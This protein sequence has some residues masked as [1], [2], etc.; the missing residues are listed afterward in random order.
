MFSVQVFELHRILEVQKQ[1]AISPNLLVDDEEVEEEQ[2]EDAEVPLPPSSPP[3]IAEVPGETNVSKP[4]NVA[5]PPVVEPS[6]P[7]IY[8]VHLPPQQGFLPVHPW[9]ASPY[10]VNPWTA[11][12]GSPYMYVPYPSPYPPAGYGVYPLMGSD[13]AMYER[14]GGIPATTFPV[15]QPP[16]ISQSWGARDPA[17]AA[18]WYGATQGPVMGPTETRVVETARGHARVDSSGATSH[19]QRATIADD[20]G[21]QGGDCHTVAERTQKVSAMESFGWA[22][23]WGRTAGRWERRDRGMLGKRE[24]DMRPEACNVEGIGSA[25][26]RGKQAM[27][28]GDRRGEGTAECGEHAGESPEGELGQGLL[29]GTRR[30]GALQERTVNRPHVAAESDPLPL[31]PVRSA[32]LRSMHQSG[33]IKVVPRAFSATPESAAG[34]L[35]SIQKERQQ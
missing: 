20:T 26:D 12:M 9:Q 22:K 18:A 23:G 4:S 8:P 3:L 30:R 24:R 11:R 1:I 32:P 31:F 21:R 13:V 5:R 29:G 27:D 6:P 10:G 17:A 2:E 33:V 34:I 19:V 14:S 7:P 28:C 25:D 35:L 15:W 16:G